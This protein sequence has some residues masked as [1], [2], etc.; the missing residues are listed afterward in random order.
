MEVQP[1][2]QL[3]R[4]LSLNLSGRKRRIDGPLPHGHLV[5]VVDDPS[6]SEESD[7]DVPEQL[8]DWVFATLPPLSVPAPLPSSEVSSA[9]AVLDW[10]S[11]PAGEF[12]LFLM[13]EG[14]SVCASFSSAAVFSEVFSRARTLFGASDLWATHRTRPLNE[15]LNGRETLLTHRVASDDTIMFIRRVYGGA[16]SLA[17][18]PFAQTTFA[19]GFAAANFAPV[20]DG[21]EDGPQSSRNFISGTSAASPEPHIQY[22][23]LVQQP[24]AQTT[25]AFVGSVEYT[26]GC[27]DSTVC[28]AH[29]RP[30]SSSHH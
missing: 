6:E 1:R 5:V 26:T 20:E 25:L 16:N 19:L 29:D 10:T 27:V 12:R 7:N 13:F 15:E 3:P 9:A 23:G 28:R 8:I 11:A 30:F 24:R 2:L 18:Q 14:R 17:P 21:G 22:A 4:T